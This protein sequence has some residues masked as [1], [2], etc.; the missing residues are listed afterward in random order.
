[1]G[2]AWDWG[3]APVSAGPPILSTSP[4]KT[5][6]LAEGMMLPI[7]PQ[8]AEPLGAWKPAAEPVLP[9]GALVQKPQPIETSEDGAEVYGGSDSPLR[10]R[11][12]FLQSP[13]ERSPSLER[14]F[15]E[16]KVRSCPASGPHSR[17]AS[18][19]STP[20]RPVAQDPFG[21][22]PSASALVTPRDRGTN[23]GSSLAI[24]TLPGRG[25]MKPNNLALIQAASLAE[26]DCLGTGYAGV[27]SSSTAS[28]SGGNASC[29]G[30]VSEASGSGAISL[31]Q[32]P[33]TAMD[34]SSRTVALVELPSKG[35]ALH[36]WGACKPCAFVF[37]VGC[38]N[39]V[40]CQF[41]HLCEPGEKKRRKKERRRMAKDSQQK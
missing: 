4:K 28:T 23:S 41:C 24:G 1:M 33:G 18:G 38:A 3:A 20:Q 31:S 22:T 7:S 32:P 34:A 6:R 5:G 16:R 29:S 2:S 13:L 26:V 10:I 9:I 25:V 39:G 11:N 40:N 27:E 36:P 14:F 17:R 21:N 35:S 37:E 15:A 30:Q 12:T 19:R 8:R